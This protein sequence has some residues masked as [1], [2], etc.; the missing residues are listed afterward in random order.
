MAST[1]LEGARTRIGK[2]CVPPK[3]WKRETLLLLIAGILVLVLLNGC[4]GAVSASKTQPAASQGSFQVTPASLSFGKVPVGKVSSQSL[5]VSNTGN[6]ALNITQATF[7]N[8]QFSLSGMT[9]PMALAT[10]QGGSFSV[11]VNPTSAGAI[12]GT[13]TVQGDGGS[14]PVV[15]NLSATAVTPQAQLS[16]STSA[17]NF[18]SVSIGS[19]GSSSLTISNAGTADLTISLLTLSGSDFGISGITTPKTI[20][21]GQNAPVTLTFKPT[22]A[23]AASG[24]LTITSNDPTTPSAVV[25]LSWNRIVHGCR[26]VERQSGQRELRK[27]FDQQ[28]RQPADHADKYGKCD[29]D[30]FEHYL[31]RDR[32][33]SDWR[34]HT[35]H[36]SGFANHE[37]YGEILTDGRWKCHG[38]RDGDK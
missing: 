27:C 23:G 29:R 31:Q 35:G 5:S 24:S 20:S 22:L 21:A 2:R 6:V 33:Q 12:T 7:S 14:S 18:G 17:V 4:A 28:Q 10:G 36:G 13:L 8:P 37:L 9:P 30:H 16:L 19:T 15:V 26:S 32:I 34:E 11:S 1:S 3:I 25:S 38:H